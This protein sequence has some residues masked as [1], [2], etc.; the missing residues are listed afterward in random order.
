M[1]KDNFPAADVHF[2]S[3]IYHDWTPEQCQLLTKKSFESLE[4]GGRLIIHEWLFNDDRTQPLSTAA[5][6]LIMLLW[7]AGG[8]Q[9]SGLE[10]SNMLAEVGFV[11]VEVIP[12]FGYWSIVTGKKPN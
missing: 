1:W 7:C 8:Q 2:Y 5:Y 3:L 4:P 12:T 9:Y 11:E 6:N 10:L